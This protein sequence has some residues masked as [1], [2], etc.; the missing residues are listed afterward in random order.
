MF[1]LFNPLF[2]LSWLLF[3]IDENLHAGFAMGVDKLVGIIVFLEGEAVAYKWLQVND[4]LAYVIDGCEIIFVA[5]HHRT[6]ESQLVF[7]QIEHAEG[8]IL[9]KDS[10][11]YDVATFSMVSISER[12]ETS[13]PATSKPT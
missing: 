6:D 13:T 11:N 1:L 10:H 7:A 8:W 4:A 3:E 5:V 12:M 2:I 9:G